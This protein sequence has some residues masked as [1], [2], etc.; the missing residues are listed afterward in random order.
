MVLYLTL[1]PANWVCRDNSNWTF[2]RLAPV[3]LEAI[4]TILSFSPLHI[5]A[6]QNALFCL[7]FCFAKCMICCSC[8]I[9]LSGLVYHTIIWCFFKGKKRGDFGER[10]KTRCIL[11]SLPSL[12]F[13][14]VK[15]S[16]GYCHLIVIIIPLNPRLISLVF[17][18]EL[19]A[20]FFSRWERTL[21]DL[22]F[23]L[24]DK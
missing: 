8:S 5:S 19:S 14:K 16:K 9:F 18:T 17:H 1:L 4:T 3:F 11:F 22:L 21:V 13:L 2:M 6:L 23:F 7:A 12:H 20:F 10:R 24:I 15:T